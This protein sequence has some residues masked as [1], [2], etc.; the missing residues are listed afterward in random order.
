MCKPHARKLY[1]YRTDLEIC[2]INY[3]QKNFIL[4]TNFTRIIL[5]IPSIKNI[6]IFPYFFISLGTTIGAFED[7]DLLF[8]FLFSKDLAT[9][10]LKLL[11]LSSK[12]E[13]K[14][15]IKPLKKAD[16]KGNIVY[17]VS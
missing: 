1:Q 4:E 10:C 15:G 5:Y 3:I 16:E 14:L 11:F 8:L 9:F 13:D 17:L 6:T 12:K 7:L 2:E